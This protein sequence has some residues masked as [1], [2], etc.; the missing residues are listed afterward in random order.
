MNTIITTKKFKSIFFD[1]GNTLL[2]PHPSVEKVCAEILSDHGYHVSPED[3]L[4]ALKKADEAYEEQY[5]K[6]DRFWLTEVDA[7]DFWAGLYEL[8]LREVGVDGDARFIAEKIYTAFGQADRW[9]PFDDVIPVFERLVAM[10]YNLGLISNWDTRLPSLMVETGLSKYL[11]FV[12]S[13][14]SVGLLKP[15]PQIFELALSRAGV[16]AAEALHVGDHYYADVLGARSVGITPILIDRRGKVGSSDCLLIK[17]LFGL[18]DY[19]S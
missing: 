14:A 18:L 12:I 11:D 17:D 13:S 19:L 15:Q 6:D 7:A 8:I 9:Q 4:P 16:E 2:L 3:L 1:V 5:W 10:G